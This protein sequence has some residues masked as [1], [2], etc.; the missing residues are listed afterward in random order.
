MVFYRT[1]HTSIQIVELFQLLQQHWPYFI[2][3]ALRWRHN[4]HAG[5]SNHQPHGCL[6]NRLFR[7]KS[8]K[9]S[10]LR[11]SGFVREIHRGPVN[12]PHKW[13][14]TRKMFPF[15]DVIMDDILP[16]I[17]KK[18]YHALNWYHKVTGYAQ[19][20]GITGNYTVSESTYQWFSTRLQ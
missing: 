8:K 6:L 13:P 5:V 9:T 11:V 18:S 3:C 10:K 15:D 14:V 16:V 12:F 2:R 7:R 4:D 19:Q 1:S 20:I 17:P